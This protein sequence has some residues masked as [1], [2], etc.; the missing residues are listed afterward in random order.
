M[1]NINWDQQLIQKMSVLPKYQYTRHD[2]IQDTYMLLGGILLL[3]FLFYQVIQIM[4]GLA[5]I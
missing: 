2:L 3:S 1:N 4:K 5:G